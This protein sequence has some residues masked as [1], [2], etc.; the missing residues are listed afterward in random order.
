MDLITEDIRV[1]LRANGAAE[2]ETD[3]IPVVKLFDPCGRGTWIISEMMEDGD[4]MFGLCDLGF[5]E[6]GYVSLGEIQSVKNRLG[7]GIERDLDFK[8]RFPLSVYT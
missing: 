5:P 7:L 8:P 2:Q 1:R 4:S 6:L 3:H